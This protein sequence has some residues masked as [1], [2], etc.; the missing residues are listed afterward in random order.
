MS[1]RVEVK[2]EAVLSLSCTPAAC[3]LQSTALISSMD[4]V[5]CNI[6]A[7]K[8]ERGLCAEAHRQIGSRDAR[9]L[10]THSAC[11]SDCPFSL[12]LLMLLL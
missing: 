9:P 11:N 2:V 12:I 5:W 8:E 7:T 6:L 3:G 10:A 4:R 1:G